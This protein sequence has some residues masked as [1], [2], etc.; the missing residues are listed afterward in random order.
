MEES[1]VKWLNQIPLSLKVDYSLPIGYGEKL[2]LRKVLMQQNVPD[3]LVAQP[4]C[5]M[6]FGSRIAKLENKHEKGSDI[7]NRLKSELIT[8]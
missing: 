2:L 4:K 1:L 6:Q 3:N 8:N 5:A 7:C